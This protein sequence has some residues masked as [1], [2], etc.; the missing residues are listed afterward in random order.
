MGLEAELQEL[1]DRVRAF[2]AL[3][4]ERLE[5]LALATGPG[6]DA[7]SW[8]G[9]DVFRAIDPVGTVK[10][11]LNAPLANE[12]LASLERWRN[13]LALAPLILTWLG[14]TVAATGYQAAIHADASLLTQPFLLLWQEGFLGH[15]P[16]LLAPL[17]VLTFSHVALLDVALLSAMLL[18]TWKIHGELNVAGSKRAAQAQALEAKLQ[19]ACWRAA[20]A[21]N[22]RA[23]PLVVVAR[24]R[25]ASDALLDELYAERARIDQIRDDRERELAD[26]HS[27]AGA[28]KQ[29]AADLLRSGGEVRATV[30]TLLQVSAALDDR[31]AVLTKQQSQLETGIAAAGKDIANAGLLQQEA[32]NQLD[33]A[34]RLLT[35]TADASVAATSALGDV[36]AQ[37]RLEVAEL[38]QQWSALSVSSRV[39]AALPR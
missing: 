10:V 39:P 38:R 35:D 17:A 23:S 2:D 9:M 14:L 16:R 8:C 31:L 11:L 24:F 21:L 22:E 36:L 28:L 12:R 34:A 1:A 7:G 27:F 19:H 33:G 32:C 6:G 30:D 37:L 18:I 4:A 25:E 20:L 26:L 29:G 13:A 15:M 5:D 3:V